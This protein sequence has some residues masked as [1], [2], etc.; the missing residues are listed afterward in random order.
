MPR[1]MIWMQCLGRTRYTLHKACESSLPQTWV[2]KPIFSLRE[3]IILQSRICKMNFHSLVKIRI[4]FPPNF[5]TFWV[6]NVMDVSPE[7]QEVIIVYSSGEWNRFWKCSTEVTVLLVCSSRARA[8]RCWH[9]CVFQ[10][11]DAVTRRI[12]RK[13]FSFTSNC[14][15]W[16]SYFEGLPTAPYVSPN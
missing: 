9:F 13:T 5:M 11:S 2:A 12:Q 1:W 14:I 15:A 7:W 8:G 16:F 6:K 10:T 4:T 3:K